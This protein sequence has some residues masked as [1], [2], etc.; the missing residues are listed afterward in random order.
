MKRKSILMLML[1]ATLTLGLSAGVFAACTG[2]D[3]PPEHEHEYTTWETVTE[4]TCEGEGEERSVCDICNEP[5]T[6]KINPIG[7][8]WKLESTSD[9][10]CTEDGEE[11]YVCLHDATHVK[12]EVLYSTGHTPTDWVTAIA[13]TCEGEGEER[14]VCSVCGDTTTRKINPIGHEWKLDSTTDPTCT[15]DGAKNYVCLHD[16]NHTK[17]EGIDATGHTL[18]NKYKD[19]KRATCTEVG[20]NIIECDVCG[21]DVRVEIPMTAHNFSAAGQVT[22]KQPACTEEG[23]KTGHCIECDQDISD[24]IPAL[25]HSWANTYNITPAGWDHD[26]EKYRECIRC[27]A[28]TDVTVIPALNENTVASYSISIVRNNGD[29]IPVAGVGY[30]IYDSSNSL[31]TSGNF[32]NGEA[33]VRINPSRNNY[34]VV[35]VNVPDGYTVSDNYTLNCENTVDNGKTN[36]FALTGALRTGQPAPNLSYVTGSV[37]YDFT[38]TTVRTNARESQTIT[39]SDL[40]K[41]YKVVVLNFWYVGCQFCRYEFPGMEAA[42]KQYRNDVAIIAI[43]N[44]TDSEQSVRN[45]V[46][47]YGLSFYVAIDNGSLNLTKRFN[48]SSFPTTVVIDREGVVCEIHTSAL[49]NPNDYEDLVFCT[50]QFA[51]LFQ[52]YCNTRTLTPASI[53]D[54]E[55]ILP[56]K[57]NED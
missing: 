16:A 20:Y 34:R 15:E 43:D 9:P 54:L 49:V 56:S 41:D 57:S 30:E 23:V 53:A 37:M 40:L 46:N 24:P 50:A 13:A 22:T 11:I 51:A 8:E 3:D 32:R 35:L 4:A 39:L 7:H 5:V 44:G 29:V 18:T 10:T 27:D 6:R 26:G 42:Y 52:K 19:M 14:S 28:I 38:I 36:G 33:T 45:F 25:G 21:E 1:G 2:N 48:V 31:V 12:T 17:S 55:Y 47:N